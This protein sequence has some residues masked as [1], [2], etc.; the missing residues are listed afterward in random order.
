MATFRTRKRRKG[1]L[2]R[3]RGIIEGESEKILLVASI[4]ID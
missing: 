3:L 1:E 4:I 2:G